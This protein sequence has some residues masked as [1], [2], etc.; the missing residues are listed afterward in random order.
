MKVLIVTRSLTTA[1]FLMN[2]VRAGTLNQFGLSAFASI[3]LVFVNPA[4][5]QTSLT[6]I[7]TAAAKNIAVWPNIGLAEWTGRCYIYGPCRTGICDSGCNN[8]QIVKKSAYSAA[9]IYC[10]C[11]A[12]GWSKKDPHTQY[13]FYTDQCA[14]SLTVADAA[15][16]C[17]NVM[18]DVVCWLHEQPEFVQSDADT[19]AEGMW[20]YRAPNIGSAVPNALGYDGPNACPSSSGSS[21]GL[22]GL[23][24]LLGIIPLC[25]CLLGLL[26][27]C[28]RRK[29]REG[30]VHFATFDAAA[31]IP[32]VAPTACVPSY[33]AVSYQ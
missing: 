24:G 8:G 11:N 13:L 27:C 6:A 10:L 28:I 14:K 5:K 2:A 18:Q 26:L 16:C 7:P 29:K 32:A 25:C 17:K 22:L 30:D 4:G 15:A 9:D 33:A 12:C 3:S 19:L 1:N 31:S 21:K 23:L 20:A